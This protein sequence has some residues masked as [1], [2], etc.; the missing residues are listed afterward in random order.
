MKSF[1]IPCILDSLR[2]KIDAGTMT[3]EQAARELCR[4]GWTNFV[5]I[6][7][8][9][10]LLNRNE[11]K[12]EMITNDM[13]CRATTHPP[14]GGFFLCLHKRR[15]CCIILAGGG[16]VAKGVYQEWIQGEGLERVREQVAEGVPDKDIAKNL[17]GISRTTLYEWRQ[18]Y[19]D[20]AD[21]FVY[22]SVDLDDMLNPEPKK[23]TTYED[24]ETVMGDD[25]P[26]YLGLLV[27]GW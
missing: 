26:N 8:T 14:C 18:L 10:E 2:R 1:D 17:I 25:I 24:A 7:E 6:E 22:A 3:I 9:R 5:D 20:F 16:N 21:A 11:A 12:R 27:Q 15:E 19:P 4:A 13:D 23:Q